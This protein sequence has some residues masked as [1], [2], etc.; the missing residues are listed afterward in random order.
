MPKGLWLLVAAIGAL[1]AISRPAGAATAA[2][3]VAP[4]T[5]PS[6]APSAQVSPDQLR[7]LLQTLED[8]AARAK[9]VA[10]LKALIAVQQPV[11]PTQPEGVALLGRLSSTRRGW[12][13][14]RASNGTA[15]PHASAGPRR[16]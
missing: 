3:A 13:A 16:P 6:P 5:A 14:G 12:C 15:P 4:A 8:P 2:V 10:E 1:I 7:S 11:A 9:L